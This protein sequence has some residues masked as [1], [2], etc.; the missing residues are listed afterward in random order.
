MHFGET[1]KGTVAFS[2]RRDNRSRR[3]RASLGQALAP[4]SDEQ[5]LNSAPAPRS[6]LKG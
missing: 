5:A 1:M 3:L 2:I 6:P 4:R